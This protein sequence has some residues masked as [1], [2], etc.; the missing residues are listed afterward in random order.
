[1]H[2]PCLAI[3]CLVSFVD[4]FLS[5][6]LSLSHSCL[7]LFPSRWSSRALPKTANDHYPLVICSFLGP[8]SFPVPRPLEDFSPTAAAE[9]MHLPKTAG[10]GL[11]G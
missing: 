1:M 8:S 5:L 7:S 6:S 2:F 3:S 9:P 4:V 11:R 10:P